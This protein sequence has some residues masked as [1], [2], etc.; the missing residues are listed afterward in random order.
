MADHR[1]QQI[2]NYRLTRLLGSGGF[3]NAY[4]GEPVSLK[5]QATGPKIDELLS[6]AG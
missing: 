2:G 6:Y 1:G 5:T 4:L 3:A